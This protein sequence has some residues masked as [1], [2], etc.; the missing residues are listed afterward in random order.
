LDLDHQR[1][2]QEGR[3]TSSTQI[4]ELLWGLEIKHAPFR[5]LDG[6]NY[7]NDHTPTSSQ[8]ALQQIE[9]FLE[10][11]GQLTSANDHLRV[12]WSSHSQGEL[13]VFRVGEDLFFL[14]GEI[15]TG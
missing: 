13:E 14:H 15:T 11:G 5:S 1:K 9:L 2:F 3:L 7:T 8:N 4:L 6:G 10:F 12:A